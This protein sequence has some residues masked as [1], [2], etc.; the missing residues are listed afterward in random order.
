MYIAAE[1]SLLLEAKA[2]KEASDGGFT[3]LHVA[4]GERHPEVV[5]VR[6][7]IVAY[8]AISWLLDFEI[9]EDPGEVCF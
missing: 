6:N 8:C 3:P 9:A 2:D 5:P 1:Q 4:D 7:R